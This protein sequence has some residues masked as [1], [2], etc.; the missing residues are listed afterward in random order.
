M[1]LFLILVSIDLCLFCFSAMDVWCFCNSK[2][3]TLVN[4]RNVNYIQMTPMPVSSPP[5][6]K[7]FLKIPG[8]HWSAELPLPLL[9]IHD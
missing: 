9:L 4:V 5:S 2:K 7:S 3:S 6:R 8:F 1:G